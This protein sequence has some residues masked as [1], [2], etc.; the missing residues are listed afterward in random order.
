MR[1]GIQIGLVK[2]NHRKWKVSSS[3]VKAKIK[4]AVPIKLGKLHQSIR[5][6]QPVE[7][8]FQGP[9]ISSRIYH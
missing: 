6:A 2:K 5:A 1:L 8:T 9:H 4:H 7:D 3:Y